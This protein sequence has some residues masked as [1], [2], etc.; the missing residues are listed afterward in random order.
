MSNMRIIY[1]NA[2]TRSTLTAS[3]T[4]GTLVAANMLN[5]QKTN[6]WR[7]IGTSA[8]LTM[9][10][11]A[12]EQIA[13]IVLPYT[14]LTP[15][16][17]IRVRGYTLPTDSVPAIDTGAVPACPAAAVAVRQWS[18]VGSGANAYAYGGGA[19]ARCW[20]ASAAVRKIVVDIVD[21]SNPDGYIEAAHVVAGAYWSPVRNPEYGAALELIDGSQNYRTDS[22]NL[23]SD[24]GT[25][26][27]KLSLQLGEMDAADRKALINILRL[28]GTV[29]PV[30]VSLLPDVSDAELERD[31]QIYGKL[32]SMSAIT[33]R[34]W[35]QYSAPIEI[36]SI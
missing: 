7:A 4:A 27:S 34:N 33:L 3:S 35:N 17:T 23:L 1:D 6:V 21:T 9:S 11:P 28:N 13:A 16:A 24:I 32:T 5:E 22:G 18:G 8:T 19:C 25:R 31:H 26:S 2:A 14:N 20:F 36:E 12:V 15:A 29:Y 10:W 30:F